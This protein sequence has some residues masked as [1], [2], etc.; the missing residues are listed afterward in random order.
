M[1]EA[2]L[3]KGNKAE[4]LFNSVD[5][6]ICS[7]LIEYSQVNARIISK[8]SSPMKP[9][10]E[11][12]LF[13]VPNVDLLLTLNS[14]DQELSNFELTAR[15]T[16]WNF[17]GR[18]F[19]TLVGN[20]REDWLERMKNMLC[21]W[22]LYRGMDEKIPAEWKKIVQGCATTKKPFKYIE[23]ILVKSIPIVN[24]L[25]TTRGLD[26]YSATISCCSNMVY[27]NLFHQ[28]SN[29]ERSIGPLSVQVL[30]SAYTTTS[31]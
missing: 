5:L 18:I 8:L 22:Y 31:N 24:H 7:K 19:C 6:W 25:Y 14:N 1:F 3:K 21:G 28:H 23:P 12:L 27:P 15:Q 11:L 26:L 9:I 20:Q 4:G 16:L 30:L 17:V 10:R 2:A 13:Y 29:L